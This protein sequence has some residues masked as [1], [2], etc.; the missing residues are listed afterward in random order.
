MDVI[1]IL[2][3]YETLKAYGLVLQVHARGLVVEQQW[4]EID[5]ETV[6]IALKECLE[7]IVLTKTYGNKQGNNTGTGNAKLA[8]E[9]IPVKK[10][11]ISDV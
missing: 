9:V 6:D 1:E 11:N 2:R 7:G 10:E 5:K 8:R 4:V 3:A